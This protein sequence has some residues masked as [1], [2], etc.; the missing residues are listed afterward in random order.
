MTP[1]E[2]RE[3]LRAFVGHDLPEVREWLFA[4]DASPDRD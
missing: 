1:E 3:A 2:S 4:G